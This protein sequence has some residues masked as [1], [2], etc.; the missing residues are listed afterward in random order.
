MDY[1]ASLKI[2]KR[3]YIDLRSPVEYI[4]DHI[5]GAMNLPLFDD[6]QR[7]KIGAI[8]HKISQD[9]ARLT[10]LELAAPRLPWLMS[11]LSALVTNKQIPILYC[12]RG[13]MRSQAVAKAAS[14]QCLP[15]LRLSGG[16]REY[17]RWVL[18]FLAE[19]LPFSVYTLYGLTGCGK[20]AVLR[21]LGR[22]HGL[23]VLD[24]EG[25]AQH[26]G[27]VFGHIGL[28]EQ[29][30]QKYFQ[31]LFAKELLGLDAT[32]P[33]LME[34]ESRRVGQLL[35]HDSLYA[36]LKVGKRILLYDTLAGRARRLLYD[37]TPRQHLKE[38]MQAL[39][40]PALQAKFSTVHLLKLKQQVQAGGEQ[41]VIEYL[42]AHYYDP[43][44]HY[45]D[46]PAKDY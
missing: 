36:S 22:D 2:D 1:A 21:K 46:S 14:L 24:I 37:Y 32:K 10:G 42:L 18:T 3:C 5:P 30:S 23:Q 40:S 15:C 20:T 29:P 8:Y 17:R 44:Y 16:Y 26:R 7:A 6:E 35:L 9:Q 43:L 41:E 25:L 38:V 12:W 45:P 11:E 31:S 33:L 27:S 19:P 28:A 4:A 34:C 39:D 13:G